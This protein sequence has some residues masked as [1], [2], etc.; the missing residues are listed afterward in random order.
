MLHDD[1]LSNDP[2]CMIPDISL[3]QWVGD[4]AARRGKVGEIRYH[5]KVEVVVE[6]ACVIAASHG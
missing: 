4:V 2:T 1:P 5:H 3:V 6:V